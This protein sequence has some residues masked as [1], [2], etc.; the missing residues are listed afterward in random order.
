VLY[1]P[2]VADAQSAKTDPTRTLAIRRRFARAMDMRWRKLREQI[3]DALIRK[4]FF[5]LT[6]SQ[7]QIVSHKAGKIQAFQFWLDSVLNAELLGDR[8]AWMFPHI[9]QGYRAGV[10]HAATGSSDIPRENVAALAVGAVSELQGIVEAFSQQTVRIFSNGLIA[11]V[12]P[13]TMHRLMRDRIVKIGMVRSH[14]LVNHMTVMAHATATLDALEAAGVSQV[15]IIPE[16]LP[17]KIITDAPR[18]RKRQLGMRELT[19]IARRERRLEREFP[20]LVN[21]ETAGDSKVCQVCQDI[22]EEGPYDIDEA[23]GL[24]PAHLNCRCVFTPFVRGQQTDAW[25]EEEHPRHP[26]GSPKGGEFAAKGE[27]VVAENAEILAALQRM[28]TLTEEEVRVI[29]DKVAKDLDFDPKKIKISNELKYFN[30]NGKRYR[31]YGEANI[32]PDVVA[33]LQPGEIAIYLPGLVREQVHGMVAHEIEHIKYQTALN[34]Y[35]SDFNKIVNLSKGEGGD[36][37]LKP[38]GS[39]RES[40][41]GQ[42]PFYAKM[43]EAYFASGVSEFANNDGVS[44]YSYEYWKAWKTSTMD[45]QLAIHETLAEMSRIKYETGKFPEHM[46]PR[47]ISYR[48]GIDVP[49]PSAAAIA[50]GEK[51]WRDLYLTV[52]EIWKTKK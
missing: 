2:H 24:I 44:S 10:K 47:I 50:E 9:E 5:G 23:R 3:A 16:H 12:K 37:V 35:Y 18:R 6:G 33:G 28:V 26:A 31:Y 14:M 40:Y 41:A 20:A 22:S 34:A 38:D 25:R 27:A 46:G 13:Q 8:G 51:L 15:G 1:V 11:N 29:A 52:D 4:D 43:H 49:Q 7:P 30:V 42:F 19:R 21:V 39:L 36:L 17:V 32:N 48:G 45:T